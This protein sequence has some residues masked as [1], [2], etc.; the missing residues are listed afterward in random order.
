[1]VWTGLHGLVGIG[2]A[3]ATQG[4]TMLDEAGTRTMRLGIVWGSI[5]PDIDLLISIII[6]AAGGNM[7]QAL[8][9]HRTLTHSF[10]TMLAL[11]LIGLV[12][13]K[14][15]ISKSVGGGLFGIA[16][17]MFAHVL[18]DLPYEVGVS[19]LWPLTSQRFGLFWSLPGVWAYLDQTLD[20]LFAAIFFYA[21]HRLAKKYQMRSRLLVPAAVASIVAFLVMVTYDLTA[22]SASQWLLVYAGIGLPFLLLILIL[23]WL[24]RRIIYSI[25]I[26]S[27]QHA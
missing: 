19:F 12:L 13:W 4:R 25:P 26:G 6:I 20:F 18:L 10:F 3:L 9:P 17:G 14:T 16:I 2:I 11:A 24:N 5:L 15:A 8:A 1:M 7:Q 22:V 27:E 21:L 23:P